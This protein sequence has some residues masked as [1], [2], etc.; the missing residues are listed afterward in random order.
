MWRVLSEEM[1]LF[2]GCSRAS[3]LCFQSAIE[4]N[5][6]GFQEFGCRTMI[7]KQGAHQKLVFNV[8]HLRD[9]SLRVFGGF[10][11]FL[12]PCIPAASLSL[13]PRVRSRVSGVFSGH[14]RIP[15]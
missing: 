5:Y 14:G 3:P 15:G 1:K 9:N 13:R 11:M 2:D 7:P 6:E 4:N 10:A 12:K 8:C